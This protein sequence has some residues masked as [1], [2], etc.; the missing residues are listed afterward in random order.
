MQTHTHT[1][2]HTH[3]HTYACACAHMAQSIENRDVGLSKVA[4]FSFLE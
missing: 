2:T 1:H 3:I 4:Y